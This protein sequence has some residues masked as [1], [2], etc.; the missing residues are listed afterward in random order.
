VQP[1]SAVALDY[2]NGIRV[3]IRIL[4]SPDFPVNDEFL[5]C[6]QLSL[7]RAKHGHVCTWL[8]QKHEVAAGQG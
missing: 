4:Q 2:F 8:D 6:P 5:L 1:E 7:L 3:K